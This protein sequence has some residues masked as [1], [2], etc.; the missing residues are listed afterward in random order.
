QVAP[1][2]KESGVVVKASPIEERSSVFGAAIE[3]SKPLG[4]N[5]LHWHQVRQLRDLVTVGAIDAHFAVA[6]FV[7]GQADG[8]FPLCALQ[9][10]MQNK[11]VLFMANHAAWLQ[12]AKRP[13]M[14]ERIDGFE[15]AGFAAAVGANQEVKAGG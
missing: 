13:A 7:F 1:G 10:S 8:G 5:Q 12:T 4:G 6:L 14:A 11:R 2:G 15:H 3:Q 9:T